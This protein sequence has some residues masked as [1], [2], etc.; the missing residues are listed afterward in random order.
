VPGIPTILVTLALAVLL[1][2]LAVVGWQRLTEDDDTERAVTSV[3]GAPLA[4]DPLTSNV[5]TVPSTT[6]PPVTTVPPSTTVGPFAPELGQWGAW[7]SSPKQDLRRGASGD[8]VKYLQGVLRL[9]AGAAAVEIDGI[10]GPKTEQAVKDLQSAS[11]L[12]PDGLVAAG[13]WVVIDQLATGT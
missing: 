12:I 6:A 10:F 8:A 3:P 2:V 11:G 1:G 4:T 7:P 5:V 13:T 9:R